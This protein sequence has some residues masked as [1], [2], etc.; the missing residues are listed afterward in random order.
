MHRWRCCLAMLES[1]CLDGRCIK[2]TF[3]IRLRLPPD[4]DMAQAGRGFSYGKGLTVWHR[5]ALARIA[6]ARPGEPSSYRM[7]P[8][9]MLT[10]PLISCGGVTGSALQT[11]FG[12][13]W[14]MLVR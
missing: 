5:K 12:V 8:T 10:Q 3:A 9:G 13:T 7:R 1:I 11:Y 4:A 2:E 14:L 6:M